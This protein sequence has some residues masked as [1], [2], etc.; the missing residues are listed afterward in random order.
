MKTV[1]HAIVKRFLKSILRTLRPACCR[2]L[3]AYSPIHN[4]HVVALVARPNQNLVYWRQWLSSAM[5][6]VGFSQVYM[7]LMNSHTWEHA[8]LVTA[9]VSPRFSGALILPEIAWRWWRSMYGTYVFGL[10][11]R[12]CYIELMSSRYWC[13]VRKRGQSQRF[14]LGHWM[15]LIHSHSEKK[16]FRSR[17]S[18]TLPTLLSRRLP[19]ALQFV[20]LLKQDGSAS[21]ATMLMFRFQ[22]RSSSSYQCIAPTTKRLEE[23]RGRQHET[24]GWGRLMLT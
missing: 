12:S 13:M 24:S 14:L 20:L 3:T 10:T 15:S 22:T 21:L 17:I 7:W 19:A 18:D 8:P 23:T 9:V 4:K 6:R 16:S 2:R 11:Q 5:A 1:V